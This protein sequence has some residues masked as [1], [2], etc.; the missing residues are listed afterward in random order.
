MD[1]RLSR[2]RA[3]SHYSPAFLF[4]TP[5]NI[6]I[7]VETIVRLTVNNRLGYISYVYYYI[8]KEW[9]RILVF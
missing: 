7:I 1:P 3:P 4:V 5:L 2:F 8:L 6:L 9:T